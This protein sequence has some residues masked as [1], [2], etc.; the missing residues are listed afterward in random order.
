MGWGQQPP[1]PPF[2]KKPWVIVVGVLLAIGVI[3]SAVKG[4]DR[5]TTSSATTGPSSNSTVAPPPPTTQAVVP[6]PTAAAPTTQ[7]PPAVVNFTM[8]NF[9]GMDLQSAQN[10]VQTFGPFF[11]RSHDLL[12]SRRQVVDSN[13][14]VCDQNIPAGQQV[15]GNAEGLIDFGVVKREESCP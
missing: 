5:G 11:S 3:G 8:P 15:T 2:Y 10:L 14:M 12:G 4:G 6:P 1:K 13:W 7:A 9:V